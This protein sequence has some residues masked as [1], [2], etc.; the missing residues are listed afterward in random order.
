MHPILLK[1]GPFT[2]YS[3]GMMVA[4][5][6]AAAVFS[7]Y[8]RAP[9]FQIDKN[10]ML[11]LCIIILVSGIVGARLLYVLLNLPY[12]AADPI[13]IFKLSKGGLVWYGGFLSALGA[14]VLY[15][16]MAKLDFWSVMDL[17]TP[18]FALGQ[19]FGR[20]GCLLNG[21]CYGLPSDPGCMLAVRSV[22]DPTPRYPVQIYA[23][24]ALFLIFLILR[25]WQDR[26][27]F[28][29]EIALGYCALYSYKRFLIEFLRAD[30]PRILFGLTMSQL[31]S[32]AVLFMAIVTFLY[33]ANQWKRKN[34]HLR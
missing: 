6:F 30:N 22:N 19:A 7:I 9:K 15:L 10:K 29:G 1:I 26:K 32:I 31:I 5:G 34:S 24:V 8:R 2:I 3:Y 23:A 18:Y 12:Y 14:A 17:V 11:D 16:R 27:N 4:I 33:K 21:C 28:T 13:E 25:V 20:I